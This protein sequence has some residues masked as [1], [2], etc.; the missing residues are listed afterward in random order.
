[1]PDAI[2]LKPL[3]LRGVH[4][5]P[6]LFL[7]P[8][9]NLTHSAGRRLLSDFG[10]YGAL[11]TEMLSAKMLLYENVRQSPWLKRRPQ[12]GKVIYQLLVTDTGSL[13]EIIDRLTP[14]QPNGLDLNCACAAPTI[15][16]QHGGAAL[17]E[18]V[19][20]MAG[21]VRIMRRC[22]PGPLTVKIRLGRQREDWRARLMERIRVLEGEGVDALILHPRFL[23]EKFRRLARHE[24]YAEIAAATRMP[25]IANGDIAGP[26]YVN[27]RAA[28]FDCVSGLM[29]GRRAMAQ[30]WLFGQW[31]Q[32]GLVV[33]PAEIARRLCGY[34]IED[35]SP[36]KAMR[37]LKVWTPY[38][39]CNFVFGHSLFKAVQSA[40]DWDT[41]VQRLMDFLAADPERLDPITVD[42][43]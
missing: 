21:I 19:D 27:E 13:P 43:L 31:R 10:G 20:A 18:E 8:M 30:P 38:F 35:F 42:G 24:L 7:A 32:P 26:D 12:E 17:F 3:I 14:L 4:F 36:D 2:H 25:L 23:E 34:L 41:A 6:P 29:V 33:D 22:F 1:M 37:R 5:D 15:L 40:P 9:A 11:F 39:A 28:Q 16:Q